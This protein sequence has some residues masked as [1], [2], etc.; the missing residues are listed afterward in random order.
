MIP[1]TKTANFLFVEL[2]EYVKTSISFDLYRFHGKVKGR[3]L[4]YGKKYV[5]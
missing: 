5:A 4:I 3:I 1:K 2:I